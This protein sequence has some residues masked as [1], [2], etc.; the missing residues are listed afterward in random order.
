MRLS[1]LAFLV[2][3]LS[4]MAALAWERDA[5]ACGGC[6]VRPTERTVVTDHRMAF[7]VSTTQTVLWDQIKYQG[8]PN[9]FAWVLPVRS[10]AYIEAS[11]DAWF[12]AL[13]ASTQPII[14]GPAYRGGGYGCGLAGC[15]AS[16]GGNASN[17]VPGDQVQI[18]SQQ[19]V[20]PYETVTLRSSNG[21]ALT[22]WLTAHSFAIPAN[23]QPTIDAYTSEGFDFIALRL[24]PRCGE[25]SMRP[26]RIVTPGADATLPLRMVAAGV[27]AQ[28]GITLYVIGEGRYRP[29]NF[30]E[31]VIDDFELRWD[32]SANRSNYAE[33]SQSLMAQANGHTWLTEYAQEPDL[34]GRGYPYYSGSYYGGNPG[35]ADAYYGL[36]QSPSTGG[37]GRTSPCAPVPPDAS[38]DDADT[39]DAATDAEA[40]E[41]G[42]GFSEPDAGIP[43]YGGYTCPG[44]DDLTVAARGITGTVWVTR[45]RALLP[46]NALAEGDLRLEASPVQTTVTNVHS[47]TLYGDESGATSSTGG[48]CRSGVRGR[49]PFAGAFVAGLAALAAAGLLRR[50]TRRS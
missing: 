8:N 1:K 19:V 28:V 6:F 49:A 3:G 38:V 13:D 25:Q 7:S 17:G 36:C 29:Q 34:S 35:L 2:A 43:S 5:R 10:G 44:F 45:M 37:G 30:P 40:A 9:E 11:N 41:A 24:A 22:S 20:G 16:G 14:S 48:A 32:R 27:G 47:A 42:T 26:V 33:L 12:A 23:I 21:E 15:S 39:S 50:R 4:G 31:A 18:L 46:S